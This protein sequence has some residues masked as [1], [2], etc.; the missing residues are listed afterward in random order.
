MKL[1]EK[2]RFYGG[3]FYAHPF[4][5]FNYL[6]YLLSREQGRVNYLP[7]LLTFYVSDKC[8]LHCTM[9][10]R[11]TPDSPFRH[12]ILPDLDLEMFKR[13]LKKFPCAMNV[14]FIGQGEPFLNDE[15]FAM[16]AYVTRGAR[17]IAVTTNGLALDDEKAK[18]LFKFSVRHLR[19]S[20]KGTDAR[21]FNAVSGCPESAF[22]T[23]LANIRNVVALKKSL[24]SE[25]IIELSYIVDTH[26]FKNMAKVIA[27]AEDLG[28]D[29]VTLDNLI[30]FDDFKPAP[31][32]GTLCL[33]EDQEEVRRE[34]QRL[35]A[36]TR[37]IKVNFPVLLKRDNFCRYCFSYYKSIMVDARGN[38]VGCHRILTP[39][40]IYGNVFTDPDI[41]NTPHFVEMRRRFLD[42]TQPLLDMCRLCTEMAEDKRGHW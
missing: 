5:V 12:A 42:G 6:K 15:I 24:R 29:E 11:N 41:Y 30:P 33:F 22:Y 10:L 8:N 13:I 2:I 9:C 1:F 19:F 38:V 32:G 31:G 34:I 3:F 28:V 17:G 27:L 40:P 23:T 18:K 25:L 4:C 14:N 26:N 7:P 35:A 16:F 36:I 37:R 20:L 21:E 39:S